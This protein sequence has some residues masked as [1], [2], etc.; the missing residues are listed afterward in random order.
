[1]T[2]ELV[3]DDDG[4]ALER[5]RLKKKQFLVQSPLVYCSII[6]N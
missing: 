1:M 4:P 2:A 6:A 5:S 3:E